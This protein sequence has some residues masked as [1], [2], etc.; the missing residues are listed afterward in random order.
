MLVILISASMT[1]CVRNQPYRLGQTTASSRLTS[2]NQLPSEVDPISDKE[3][4]NRKPYECVHV[5]DDYQAQHFYLAHIEFDDMGEFWSIGDLRQGPRNSESQLDIALATIG[6]AQELA[7][8]QGRSVVVITFVHGWHNNSSAYDEEHKDL[9]SFKTVLQDLSSRYSVEFPKPPVLVG[10]FM[11]WRGQV[12]ADDILATYWNRRDAAVRIGGPSF[13]EAIVRLMFATKGVLMAP[14][15]RDA[16]ELK[17]EK[18]NSHFIVIGHSFGARALEHAVAQPMLSL[19]LERQAQVEACVSEWNK[20]HPALSGVGFDAPADLI[21]FL[22]AANDAFETKATIEALKRSDIRVVRNGQSSG[23]GNSTGPFMISITSDGDWATEKIM[24][25]AQLLSMPGFA[26][27]HYAADS[28]A[29]GQLAISKQS[30]F[31]RHSAASIPGM[32][33][34][35]VCERDLNLSAC[36]QLKKN[37]ESDDYPY[38]LTETNGTERCFQIV[39]NSASRMRNPCATVTQDTNL[40][41]ETAQ[42][43]PPWND[44]PAFVVS[45]PKSLIPS[46]TDIFQDGT[47]ELLITISNYFNEALTATTRMTT[48]PKGAAPH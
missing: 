35:S 38:F 5:G 44:T 42:V 13:T 22:N 28:Q 20:S 12:A 14:G 8:T 31:Y 47:E 15:P 1:G 26:F 3:C 4:G 34:H 7:K 19:I 23:D 45:V 39:E 33:S 46:H 2:R 18:Q 17:G 37:D 32:R 43:E 29:N 21:V 16:C 6:R 11:S 9:G 41:T 40:S 25:V 36:Q 27:R 48:A 30:F 24:P 10:V